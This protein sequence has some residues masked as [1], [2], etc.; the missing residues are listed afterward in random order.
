MADVTLSTS[1]CLDEEAH[2][3]TNEFSL[4]LTASGCLIADVSCLDH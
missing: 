1:C 3:I 4:E 2:H